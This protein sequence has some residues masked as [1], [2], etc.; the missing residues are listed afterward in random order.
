ME[1]PDESTIETSSDVVT[2]GAIAVISV[3]PIEPE[4]GEMDTNFGVRL[5]LDSIIEW[6]SGIPTSKY[7]F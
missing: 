3:P 4:L 1:V 5:K 7:S 2:P 6:P